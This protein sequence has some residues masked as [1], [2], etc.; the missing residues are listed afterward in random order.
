MSQNGKLLI[1]T[2][3]A[4]IKKSNKLWKQWKINLINYS[5]PSAWWEDQYQKSWV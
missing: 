4:M 5:R 2:T 3:K 1:L